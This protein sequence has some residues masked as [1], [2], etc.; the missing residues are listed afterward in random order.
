[1]KRD[2]VS[3]ELRSACGVGGARGCVKNARGFRFFT[4]RFLPS[5]VIPRSRVVDDTVFSWKHATLR[6]KVAF[7]WKPSEDGT[8][9]SWKHAT[10]QEE[11]VFRWKPSE[12]STVFSWKHATLQEEVVFRWKP[13]EDGTVFSWKHA[14]LRV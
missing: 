8:V 12:D 2:I 11:V 9:F 7:R 10:L 4:I 3:R 14:P 5:C 1:M 6:E 13:S